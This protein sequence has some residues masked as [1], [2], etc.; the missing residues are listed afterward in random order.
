MNISKF[1]RDQLPIF[2]ANPAIGFLTSGRNP[3][4]VSRNQGLFNQG[5]YFFREYT[6]INYVSG[7]IRYALI[8][9]GCEIAIS[10]GFSGCAMAYFKHN[11]H[12]YVAHISLTGIHSQDD[13]GEAWNTF[14]RNEHANI[15]E[16]AIFKPYGA[17]R[18]Y[19][20]MIRNRHKNLKPSVVGIIT[21]NLRCYTVVTDQ[22]YNP[23]KIIER[24]KH[25]HVSRYLS[26]VGDIQRFLIPPNRSD[27]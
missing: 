14:I 26:H 20:I 5:G 24:R 8:Q 6:Y 27:W 16:Y 18:T 1:N 21:R 10:N 19:N 23:I 17:N 15:E 2:L 4:I 3:I 12:F 7:Q 11:N 22:N 13:C 9:P 25:I